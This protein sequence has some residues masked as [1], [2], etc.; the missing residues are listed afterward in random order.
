MTIQVS[1]ENKQIETL[2]KVI[3]EILNQILG[4]E[5][6]QLVYYYVERNYLIQRHEIVEKLDSFNHAMEEYLGSAAMVIEKAIL[7]NLE[8][9]VLEES[10]RVD[11]VK[12]QKF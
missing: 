11:F 3:D 12:R 7:E 9:R 6:T 4:Q 5:P 10:K 8:I 2:N 1:S